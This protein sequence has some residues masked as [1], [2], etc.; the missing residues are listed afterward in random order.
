MH[1]PALTPRRLITL[2]I[3]REKHEVRKIFFTHPPI[4]SPFLV[5]NFILSTFFRN[6]FFNLC[7][8]LIVRRVCSAI[9]CTKH[10]PAEEDCS[11]SPT[12]GSSCSLWNPK[13]GCHTDKFP[14]L[15]RTFSQANPFHVLIVY[16]FTI[17]FN[18]ITPN[19][20]Q[21]FQI[22]SSFQ[23][24]LYFRINFS[25]F[26]CTFCT[27]QF[28][29]LDLMHPKTRSS[30]LRSFVPPATSSLASKYFPQAHFSN[31]RIACSFQY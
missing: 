14:P 9:T 8:S 19:Y 22:L 23:V 27:L 21:I 13:F 16:L 15:D 4:V 29:F 28:V 1:S 26:S 5:Q 25:Y 6:A 24:S 30:L 31:T 20:A 12:W 3:L 11:S 10:I 17:R 7:S 18:I 2:L